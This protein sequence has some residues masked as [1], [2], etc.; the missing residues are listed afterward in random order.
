MK[1]TATVKE[2]QAAIDTVNEKYLG[3]IR[4]KR[5]DQTGR[6]VNFTLTVI[7]SKKPGGRKGPEG[8]RIAAACWHVHGDLFDA[9]WDRNPDTVI[10]AGP[11][12][13]RGKGDNW[14]DRN[15]GS[16]MRP[17]YYSEACDC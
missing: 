3:N 10:I 6:R 14:Q 16:T 11:L 13:M 4:F 1:T 2:L 9:L 12:T 15:I 17:F 5:I 7:D 8:R